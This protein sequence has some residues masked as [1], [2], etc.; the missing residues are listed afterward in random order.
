MPKTGRTRADKPTTERVLFVPDT[1]RPFHDKKAWALFLRVARA[2]QPHRVAI[3]GDFGDFY[4]VSQHDKSP[5]GAI[6]FAE[7]IADI[8][9][10]L[11]E[12]D[13]L[14]ATHKVYVEGNHEDRVRRYV[15]QHPELHNVLTVPKLLD[16]TRRGWKYVPYKDHTRI[17]KVH[18]THDVGVASRNAIFRSLDLYQHSVVTGHTHRFMSVVEGTALGGEAKIALSF[19]WL[20]DVEQIDYMNRAKARA[21][22]ALGFGVAEHEVK[23]GHLYFTPVPILPDYSCALHGRVYR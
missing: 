20:G 5:A 13:G 1:H 7:E 2:Y 23:T 18:V 14:G 22:W 11:D 4:A 19:G 16:L 12:L 9:E 6:R 17:G 3:V 8:Q 10:G 15:M 21:S